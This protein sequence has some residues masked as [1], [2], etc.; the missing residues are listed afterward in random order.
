MGHGALKTS[1]TVNGMTS[2]MIPI[3]RMIEKVLVNGT[4]VYKGI[5]I[6]NTYR[7]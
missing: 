4:K 6:N 2:V 1:P 3:I 7:R 5:A